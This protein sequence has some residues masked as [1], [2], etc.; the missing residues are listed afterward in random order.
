MAARFGRELGSAG[1]ATRGG[2]AGAGPLSFGVFD[3][4]GEME[5]AVSVT[6]GVLMGGICVTLGCAYNCTDVDDSCFFSD[7]SSLLDWSLLDV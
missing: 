4:G 7:A 2:G 1:R 6:F 5:E 3:A